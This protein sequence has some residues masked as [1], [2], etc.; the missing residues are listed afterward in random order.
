M[1]GMRSLLHEIFLLLTYFLKMRLFVPNDI[2]L[3][4]FRG[5]DL[6]L[7]GPKFLNTY[8]ADLCILNHSITY[9]NKLR[10]NAPMRLKSG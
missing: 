7:L 10:F 3:C 8:R 2:K 1:Y 6:N 4:Y 5:N 9:S